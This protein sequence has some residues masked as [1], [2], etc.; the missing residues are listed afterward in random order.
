MWQEKN[1]LAPVI[2]S[3]C[4]RP[5]LFMSCPVYSPF[6]RNNNHEILKHP[7][8]LVIILFGIRGL[9]IMNNSKFFGLFCTSAAIL[10]LAGC[11]ASKNEPSV[12]QSSTSTVA[13]TSESSASS[14]SSDS[15]N[16]SVSEQQTWSKNPRTATITLKC[17]KKTAMCTAWMM[18]PCCTD[19]YRLSPQHKGMHRPG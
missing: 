10:L 19:F 1:I 8:T 5:C 7:T 18:T 17:M 12:S 14:A 16:N 2:F 9:C 4:F 11:T 15:Q 13:S 3:P 6:I